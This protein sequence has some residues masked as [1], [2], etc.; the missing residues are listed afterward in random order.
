MKINFKLIIFFI[1]S[2]LFSNIP[3]FSV[4]ST[5]PEI[6]NSFGFDI[7]VFGNRV[8]IS[9]PKDDNNGVS[10]GSVEVFLM[11]NSELILESKLFPSNASSHD[12]FGYSIDLYESTL[13]IG[14]PHFGDL[15]SP[16]KGPRSGIVYI[17]EHSES[18]WYESQ[19]LL[20]EDLST[21]YHFGCAVD[22][23]DEY[24]AIGAYGGSTGGISHSGSV[25]TYTKKDGLWMQDGK[26]NPPEAASGDRFGYSLSLTKDDDLSLLIGAYLKSER[27]GAAYLFTKSISSD[28]DNNVESQLSP[29]SRIKTDKMESSISYNTTSSNYNDS[30]NQIYEFQPIDLLEGDLFGYSVSISGNFLVIGSPIADGNDE[31]SGVAYFYQRGADGTWSQR[32]KIINPNGSKHD[33]FGIHV[34]NNQNKIYIGATRDDFKSHDG[35][36]IYYYLSLTGKVEILK[37][38]TTLNTQSHSYFGQSFDSDKFLF[39]AG[40]RQENSSELISTGLAYLYWNDLEI[41]QYGDPLDSLMYGYSAN[42]GIQVYNYSSENISFSISSSNKN[43]V[44]FEKNSVWGEDSRDFFLEPYSSTIVQFLVD[45]SNLSPGNYN[46]DLNFIW[47]ESSVPDYTYNYSIEI[48]HKL[49]VEKNLIP[50]EFLMEKSYPNPFNPVTIIKFQIPIPSKTTIT[51]YDLNG[52]KVKTLLDNNKEPG[53]YTIPWNASK[54]SS[55]IYF[56]KMIAGDYTHTQKVMLIK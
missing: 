23:E 47:S 39:V 24:L 6:G 21:G 55:G 9:S 56:V 15:S 17:F 42:D 3:V 51:I 40:S 11:E 13:V 7:S 32:E 12:Q 26:L 18:G 16:S 36:A 34:H 2:Y 41:V 30:W 45:A 14:A 46:V 27:K 53:F 52:R 22:I 4:N 54:Y 29:L 48:T 35:G 49:S 43:L 33:Q 8:A 44:K 50:D 19:K 20:P 28:L 10:S 38:I 25:Y 31:M 37:I 5:T 1:F